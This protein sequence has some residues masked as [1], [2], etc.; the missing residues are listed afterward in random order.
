MTLGLM[1]Q[2]A[3]V[4]AYRSSGLRV[5][6]SLAEA[7]QVHNINN[8]VNL[9]ESCGGSTVAAR[10]VGVLSGSSRSSGQGPG[11]AAVVARVRSVYTHGFRVQLQVPAQ[12]EGEAADTHIIARAGTSR[13]GWCQLQ[14]DEQLQGPQL[15]A[16]THEV[17]EASHEHM[18]GNGG[19]DGSWAGSVQVHSCRGQLQVS[20]GLQ[21]SDKSRLDMGHKQLWGPWLLAYTPVATGACRGCMHGSGGLCWESGWWHAGTQLQRLDMST[22]KAVGVSC[23]GLDWCLTCTQ[24]QRPGLLHNSCSVKRCGGSW[25]TQV[26][27]ICECRYLWGENLSGKICRGSVV[28]T[29]FFS[30]EICQGPLCSSLLGSI[31]RSPVIKAEGFCSVHKGC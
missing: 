15:L 10:D 28:V 21:A 23:R 14:T 20:L 25:G 5:Q 30:G 29:G 7:T 22:H 26:A 13:K 27:G 3:Q 18:H 31:M 8:S 17:V 4:R 1:V 9:R 12:W 6:V 16:H 19:R 24:P 2:G 11:Q